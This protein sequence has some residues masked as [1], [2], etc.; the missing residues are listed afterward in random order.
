M[1]SRGG[2]L[3]TWHASSVILS[4]LNFLD[5]FAEIGL[6]VRL[7]V[8]FGG[9]PGAFWQEGLLEV[10]LMRKPYSDFSGFPFLLRQP[11]NGLA[12]LFGLRIVQV[13]NS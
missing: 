8:L 7:R 4:F 3:S 1:M 9:G 13:L 11:P 12:D 10:H 6:N 5:N 2:G